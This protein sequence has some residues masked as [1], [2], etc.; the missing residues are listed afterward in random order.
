MSG[1]VGGRHRPLF[2]LIAQ[3]VNAQALAIGCRSGP[4]DS[5]TLI[6]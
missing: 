5:R 2:A 4:P 3:G 1:V 6:G